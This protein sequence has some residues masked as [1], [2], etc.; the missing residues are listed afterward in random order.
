MGLEHGSLLKTEVRQNLKY[1]EIIAQMKKK[2]QKTQI[3]I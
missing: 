2:K 1:Q 3:V